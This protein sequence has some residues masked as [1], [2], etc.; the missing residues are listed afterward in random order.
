MAVDG[1]SEKELTVQSFLETECQQMEDELKVG[2]SYKSYATLEKQ[3][4]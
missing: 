2:Q 1:E 4:R 3:L